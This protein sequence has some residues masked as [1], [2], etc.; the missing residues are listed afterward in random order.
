MSKRMRVKLIYSFN[1][2]STSLFKDIL[3]NLE[4]Y[5]KV[6]LQPTEFIYRVSTLE[7]F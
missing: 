2:N 5:V 6:T 4:V 7:Q 3:N 1:N